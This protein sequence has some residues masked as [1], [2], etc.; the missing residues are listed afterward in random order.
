VGILIGLVLA[1]GTNTACGDSASPAAP[2]QLSVAVSAVADIV[3]P[4]G[5]AQITAAVADQS[6]AP[7]P[8]G[9]TVQFT[10]TLGRMDPPQAAT[11]LGVATATFVPGGVTGVADV[12]AQVGTAQSGPIQLSVGTSAVQIAVDA[13]ALGGLNVLATANVSGGQAVRYEWY[14]E[15]AASPEVISATNQAR[16]IYPSPGFKDL[17]VRVTLA[18]GR[19]ILGSAAV[20]VD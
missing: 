8:D 7:A 19:R 12:R 5:V 10:T 13:R 9:T 11:R 1:V 14:F 4:N 6:G 3:P 17:T 15:R 20:I 18:D 2:T 16:Y